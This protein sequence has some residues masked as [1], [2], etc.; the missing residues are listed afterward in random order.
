MLV[1]LAIVICP[2]SQNK[3]DLPLL[4]YL[5]RPDE[6]RNYDWASFAFEYIRDEIKRFQDNIHSDNPAA[7]NKLHTYGSCL[8]FLA[9]CILLILLL[10]IIS[11]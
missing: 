11:F 2:N 5:M 3:V 10:V 9:V 1:A 4:S 6:I 8:P 7:R